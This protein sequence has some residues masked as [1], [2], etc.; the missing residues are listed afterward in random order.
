MSDNNLYGLFGGTFDPIHHGHLAPIKQVLETAALAQVTYIPSA[1]PPHREQPE[2]SATHRLAMTR[3]A[4]AE[5]SQF[6]VDEIELTLQQQQKQQASYT[7][8]TIQTLQQQ[9]PTRRYVLIVGLDA[10]LGLETWHR[11]QELQR[12][13]HI[14]AMTRPGWQLPETLPSWWQAARAESEA[15]LHDSAA[16]KILFIE[17]TPN[18]ISATQV[19]ERIDA[20]ED[21]SG[22]L[23]RKVWDYIC[24]HNLY[25]S[26][27]Y[28]GD[29]YDQ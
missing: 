29:F 10:F 21:V 13:V 26:E 12:S 16:G 22:M 15:E 5:H 8:D 27:L 6:A 28:D 2:A 3:I 19:R 9:N 24:A 11:W 14:I 17:T 20:G 18:P 4:I 7:I 25:G 23:P 1:V